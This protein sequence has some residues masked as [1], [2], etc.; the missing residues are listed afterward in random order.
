MVHGGRRGRLR[1]AMDTRGRGHLF[2]DLVFVAIRGIGKIARNFYLTFGIFLVAGGLVALAGTYAFARFANHVNSGSTQAFDE[3]VH[4]EERRPVADTAGR[5]RRIE[6]S[7]RPFQMSDANPRMPDGSFRV[8]D[9]ASV[10]PICADE[11][12]HDL[13]VKN[14]V[15]YGP[16]L[17]L[18]RF[19]D[20]GRLGGPVIY[21]M[22][23]RDRNEVLRGR[24]GNRRW[25]RYEIPR[26]RSDTI[27]V[28][29][30]YEAAR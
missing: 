6:L 26:N 21:A 28:L 19:D 5:L 15:A 12:R 16:M 24:F 18:N 2:W 29:V 3:A 27:P 22:D 4:A 10:T 17:L 8:T 1:D 7:V 9:S 13:R 23:L 30:P 20:A 14:T 11:I 25:Y